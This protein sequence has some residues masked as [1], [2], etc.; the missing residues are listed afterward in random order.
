MACSAFFRQT[1]IRG[2]YG[3]ILSLEIDSFQTIL[4]WVPLGKS[5]GI[6]WEYISQFTDFCFSTQGA[7]KCRLLYSNPHFSLSAPIEDRHL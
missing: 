3:G 2:V 5:L 4:A 1:S 6:P 7:V